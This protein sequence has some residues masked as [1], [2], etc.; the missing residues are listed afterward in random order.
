MTD[1]SRE[2]VKTT[3]MANPFDD[4]QHL[5]NTADA[6]SRACGASHWQ[7]ST[8]KYHAAVRDTL[9]AQSARI[10]ALEAQLAEAHD[11]LRSGADLLSVES[12]ALKCGIRI[13]K[14]GDLSTAPEDAHTVQAIDEIEGWIANATAAIRE[15]SE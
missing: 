15:G 13:G 2:T 14:D 10:A 7:R 9:R 4:P 3:A 12:E 11:L 1:L 6:M 5:A 8:A